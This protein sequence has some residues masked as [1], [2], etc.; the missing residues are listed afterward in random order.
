M[1]AIPE[2]LEEP[3]VFIS[4]RDKGMAA[5]DDE[6]G[7]RV[8]RA[9]CAQHLKENFTTKYSRTLK[10]LFWRIVRA[11]SVA[12]FK[13]I[14]DELRAINAPAAQYLLD[15]QP[16]LWAK[17][18]FIG[19]GF[20]HDTSNVAESV[21]KTLRLDRELPICLLLDLL[22]NRIMDLRFHRLELTTKAHEAEKWIPW[23]RGKLQEH[24]LLART[25]TVAM[26]SNTE[27]L[28]R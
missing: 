22:W 20:G 3:T 8:L 18:H 13:A 23:A 16:E 26:R 11:N 10:P 7:D 17:A 2:I 21:N 1:I 6:L 28:V 19:T 24:R 27:G 9:V 12:R 5:A 4:D 25:N 14:I 15:Q